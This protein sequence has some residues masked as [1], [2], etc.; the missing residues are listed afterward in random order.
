MEEFWIIDDGEAAAVGR[1]EGRGRAQRAEATGR[2]VAIDL[3]EG[4]A[5][6]GVS[7]VER[8]GPLAALQAPDFTL[9]DLD[10]RRHSLA[11]HRG[12]KVLLVAYGSW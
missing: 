6:L 7:A 9:P 8:S 3:E 4:A 2:P 11:A 1:E 5:Y 10:G 12:R